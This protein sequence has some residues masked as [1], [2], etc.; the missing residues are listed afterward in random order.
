MESILRDIIKMVRDTEME[1]YRQ[2]FSNLKENLNMICRY[3]LLEVWLI[4]MRVGNSLQNSL[5]E[6]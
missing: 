6:F 2:S 1:F 4:M 5:K 3:C